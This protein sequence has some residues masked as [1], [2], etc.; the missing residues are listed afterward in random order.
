[1]TLLSS[2]LLGFIQGV[3]EFLPISSSGHLAIAQNLLH[4]DVGGT[5]DNFFDVLLHLGTLIAIFVVYWRDILDMI[6]EFFRFFRDVAKRES[7]RQVPPARRLILLIIIGT[8]PLFGVLP[9]K[10]KIEALSSNMPAVGAALLITGVLLFMSDKFNRGRKSELS[11]TVLD[12]IIIGIGQAIAT[13][14]GISRSGMTISV[15]CFRGLDRR[16]AVRYSFLMSIPAV[17]GANILSLKDAAAAGID[18][19]LL[20]IYAAGVVTAAVFGYFSIRL[21][22]FVADKGKFGAFA[23][24][25]WAVGAITLIASLA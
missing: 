6:L 8:L 25:C 19:S 10:D 22:K 2:I 4:L 13:V 18:A 24:Y 23:Y 17:I 14:P 7:P 20:P 11:A 15:G 9:F 5:Q 16:F 12:V 21:L 3:A 1:M